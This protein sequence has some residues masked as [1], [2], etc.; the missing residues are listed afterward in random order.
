MN[1]VIKILILLFILQGCSFEPI[2]VNKN[3]DFQFENISSRGDEKINEIIKSNLLSRSKGDKKYN[4][5]LYSKKD[6][7]IVSTDSKG[8]PKNYKLE[9]KVDYK[10]FINQNNIYENTAVKQATYNNI[11]DKYELSQYENNIT[12]ILS[13]NIT[14][15]LLLSIKTLGK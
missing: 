1:K 11:T 8:D 14:E 4:I 5:N 3:F 7:Q 9:I 2:L 13:E 6:K 10:V 15:E 12:K